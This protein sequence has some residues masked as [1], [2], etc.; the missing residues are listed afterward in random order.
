MIASKSAERYVQVIKD[1]GLWEEYERIR[2][3]REIS[4]R[5]LGSSPQQE[6]LQTREKQ[7][8]LWTYRI[9]PGLYTGL[10]NTDIWHDN[11]T[12]N[13]FGDPIL[14]LSI[15]G[16]EIADGYRSFFDALWKLSTR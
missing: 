2:A 12:L 4:I 10:M 3:N 15:T 8:P 14:S 7:E 1:E 6:R 5:Y 13:I 16:K 9:F 11:I